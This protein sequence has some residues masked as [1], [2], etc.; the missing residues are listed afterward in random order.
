MKESLAA[1]KNIMKNYLS[2]LLTDEDVMPAK[3]KIQSKRSS[4]T[5]VVKN[6]SLNDLLQN[7]NVDIAS[8]TEKNTIESKAIP[9]KVI[10]E[11]EAKSTSLATDKKEIKQTAIKDRSYRQ[12]NF[13]AMFFDVAGLTVAVPLIELGGIHNKEKTTSIMGVPNWFKGV[14]LHRDEKINI[15]D[16]ALWIM[17]EKYNEKL[18]SSLNYQYVIMLDDSR[19]GLMAEHLVD[20]V[21]LGQDD[22]KWLDTSN[23]RPWLAG[24][25]K[26]KMCALLD[27]EALIQLF[28]EGSGIDQ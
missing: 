24:L 21:T 17:P 6:K 22:I 11:V 10:T 4:V 27:V 28:D 1:S 18:K 14:M 25:V 15:V 2:E 23:K 5:T 9:S 26:D 12:G 13:Q 19:W 16:T 8:P 7:V 3:Q 20:T